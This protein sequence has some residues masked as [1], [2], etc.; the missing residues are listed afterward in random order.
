MDRMLGAPLLPTLGT[1]YY[2]L[3]FSTCPIKLGFWPLVKP[4][5]DFPYSEPLHVLF[6]C[7]EQ[8][9]PDPHSGLS[10]QSAPGGGG[11]PLNPSR[12]S[13]LPVFFLLY[14]EVYCSLVWK[15]SGASQVKWHRK[16]MK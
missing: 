11:P 7:L 15:I 1:S 14:T 2:A 8:C 3:T 9:S 4:I 6:L 12:C 13:L 10:K 5:E 16:P